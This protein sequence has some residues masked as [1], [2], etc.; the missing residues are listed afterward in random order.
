MFE[1][2]EEETEGRGGGGGLIQMHAHIAI[3]S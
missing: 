3:V 2:D 1:W